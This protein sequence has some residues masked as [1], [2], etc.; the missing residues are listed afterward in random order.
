MIFQAEEK[1]VSVFNC[2]SS[3]QGPPC[4]SSQ[5]GRVF[6]GEAL[7]GRGIIAAAKVKDIKDSGEIVQCAD[8]SGVG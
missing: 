3:K 5:G 4:F 8:P 7:A 6:V 1:D 2:E